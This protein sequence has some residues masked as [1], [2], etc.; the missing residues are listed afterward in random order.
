MVFVP[1]KII[2]ILYG[3]DLHDICARNRIAIVGII[4][5]S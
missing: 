1:L 4:D 2:S 3:C 5:E